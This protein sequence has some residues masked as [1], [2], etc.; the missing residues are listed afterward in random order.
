MHI[1]VKNKLHRG[2][3]TPEERQAI[4]TIEAFYMGHRAMQKADDIANSLF[5]LASRVLE[6]GPYSVPAT[7]AHCLEKAEKAVN[8]FIVRHYGDEHPYEVHFDDEPKDEIATR[9]EDMVRK[10]LRPKK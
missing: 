1:R 10:I 3:Y 9:D 6:N 8:D 5:N 4:A 7:Q 2:F